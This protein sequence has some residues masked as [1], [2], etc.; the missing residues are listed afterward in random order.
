MKKSQLFTLT[1]ALSLAL[2]AACSPSDSQNTSS[3]DALNKAAGIASTTMTELDK[4]NA[5][6]DS[7]VNKDNVMDKF[8][9]AYAN[10]LNSDPDL[11][12]YGPIGVA[13][14]QDGSF[15]AFKDSNKN[16]QVDPDEK[17]L[18][19]VEADTENG[20][21]LASAGNEVAEQPHSFMGS[22]FFMGMLLGNMLSRQRMSGI[23]PARRQATPRRS[24]GF[25]QSSPSARSRAGSGS[26]ASGK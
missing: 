18:F 24:S 11:S 20:R 17:G 9:Q 5:N 15:V 7:T 6:A 21:V 10:K 25:R 26:H 4:S 3:L 1:I 12:K 19:K 13:P 23:N 2:L 22:G 14:Q 16:N 8:S